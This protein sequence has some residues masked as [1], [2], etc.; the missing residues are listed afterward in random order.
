L[1]SLLA[2]PS[3]ITVVPAVTV[4]AGPARATGATLAGPA[5]TVT[6]AGWLLS[7]PSVTTSAAT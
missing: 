3:S 5:V 4:W 1:A 2:L 6:V 7:L